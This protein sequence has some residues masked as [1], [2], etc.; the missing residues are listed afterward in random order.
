MDLLKHS[1]NIKAALFLL[2]FILVIFLFTYTQGIVNELR[3]DNGEI[4]KLYA[5]IIAQTI[6]D[7]N[8]TNLDFVF[9]EIIQKAQ[10][11]II[12]SYNKKDP[13][14]SKNIITDISNLRKIQSTMD[15]QNEA[16]PLRYANPLT[17]EIILI[18][19]LHYGDSSQ[20]EKLRWLPFIEIGAITLFILLGFISFSIIRN[21]EKR[22][23]WVGMARETAHQLGTPISSLMGWLEWMK[24]K[25]N[26]QEK[27]IDD[28]SLDL[29]RL[30]Q[31]S[32]RF[33]KMGSET[34]IEE[35]HLSNIVDNIVLYF[36]RRIP[37]M[38][39]SI[40]I[41]NQLESDLKIRANG[42]LISWA[43]EN[44][45][46]NAIDALDN[47]GIISLKSKFEKKSIII[48]IEDSGKGI[49]RK[50]WKN[51]FRPG[52]STKEQGWGLGLSLT[53]RIINE[54]HGG[55]I[56]VSQSKLGQGSTIEISLPKL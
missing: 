21:S 10:F 55:S 43:I 24:N 46:K 40:I 50:N 36:N 32:D 48:V 45:V 23:I 33:S 30:Q 5:E 11:P 26:D 56:Y 52:F 18:G 14:Y 53:S 38:G 41:E 9:D 17:N 12:Y 16:I 34:K 4:V 13:V 1:S 31:V 6:S 29:E 54:I 3:K 27:I 25:P 20:I 8:D 22:N 47:E 7:E 2:G 28:I 44:V 35:V 49:S 42:I 37:S 19:Y 15:E 51:I 39:K